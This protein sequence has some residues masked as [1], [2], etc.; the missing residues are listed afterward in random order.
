MQQYV[1][2]PVIGTGYDEAFADTALFP[3]DETWV[4]GFARK[5]MTVLDLGCGTGRHAMALAR[6]GCL[7]TGVDLSSHMLNEAKKKAKEAALSITYL[8]GDMRDAA[9]T[10]PTC[11]DLA[12]CMFSTLGMLFPATERLHFLSSLRSRLQPNAT[13]LLHVHNAA[14]VQHA[15]LDRLRHKVD[16]WVTSL[17]PG[18]RIIRNYRGRLDLRLHA[19]TADE[20]EHLLMDAGY[21]IRDF[22]PLNARRDGRC[23]DADIARHANGF[24]V[25]AQ[26]L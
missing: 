22:H 11:F 19:F 10:A 4:S 9:L 23:N 25:A 1:A 12:L 15:L 13:L 14:F 20:M 21:A 17:E 18:D 6:A 3:Y 26:S 16:A 8:Q 2:D 7:V 24:L 5:G